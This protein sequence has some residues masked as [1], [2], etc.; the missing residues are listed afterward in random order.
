MLSIG[1]QPT[2]STPKRS[3]DSALGSLYRDLGDDEVAARYLFGAVRQAR[4]RKTLREIV[5]YIQCTVADFHLRRHEVEPATVALTEATTLA[6]ELQI[7]PLQPYILSFWVLA[8]LA[9]GQID[10]AQVAATE[11]LVLARELDNPH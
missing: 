1:P 4:E 5:L 2:F 8:H 11:A 3:P 9:Q 7:K 10:E 6:S